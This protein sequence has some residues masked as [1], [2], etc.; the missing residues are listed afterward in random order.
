M[1]PFRYSSDR[2][3]AI[4]L[5]N[6]RFLGTQA[7]IFEGAGN[8]NSNCSCTKSL[9]SNVDVDTVL[10]LPIVLKDGAELINGGCHVACDIMRNI[11]LNSSE[12]FR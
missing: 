9:I 3:S 10:Q 5:S 12:K 8:S 2:P 7:I 6:I 1:S 4:H 11:F